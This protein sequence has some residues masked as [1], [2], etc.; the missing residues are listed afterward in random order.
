MARAQRVILVCPPEADATLNEAF[1]RL[2][3]EL[4]MH[5]FEVEIQTAEEAISPENLALRAESGHA[6]ASVSFV[7]NQ[8]FTTA[9]I[10]ISDRVTGKTSIRTIATP[11]GTDAASLLALRAVEL[12]RASLREFGPQSEAPKDI[13]G[14]SPQRANPTITQWA[15]VPVPQRPPP[16]VPPNP[17][18]QRSRTIWSL[19]ADAVAATQFPNPTSAYG[20]GAA[21]GLSMGYRFEPRLILAAPWFGAQYAASHATSQLHLISGFGE[22]AYLIPVGCRLELQPLAALG[23]AH[24]TTFTNTILPFMPLNAI[25]LALMPSMGLGVNVTL[26]KRWFWN[27]STRVAVLLPHIALSVDSR[28]FT[29]G[30]PML[31]VASGVG[32][33]F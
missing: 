6:V 23:L 8:A 7:R 14:A 2:R 30:L 16:Q 19:R 15:A 22:V 31:M 32:M 33:R 21:L 18:S 25:N 11:D 17:P 28:Q 10:K 12:L 20:F 3:G 26:S 27:T 24:V 13:V 1:N 29:F 4:T 5:G 9:D